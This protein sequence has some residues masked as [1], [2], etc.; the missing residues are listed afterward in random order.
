MNRVDLAKDPAAWVESLIKS[1]VAESPENS[2]KNP[3]GERAFME[4]L[5][6]FS[7]GDDPIYDQ[8]RA[9][10]G[11]FFWRPAEAFAAEFPEDPA[12]AQELTVIS[13]ILPHNPLTKA[14]N[15]EA[16]VY[17][18]ERWARARFFGEN[19]NMLLRSHLAAELNAA[20][21]PA[22]APQLCKAWARHDSKDY[23]FASSWSERHA[24]H[25]SGL[26]TFGLCD[27]LITPK[28]KAMRTG[29]VVARVKILPTPRP[30]T[31]HHAYCLFYSHG[32][33]GK[34]IPA[35]PV[36][37]L[38]EE[39]HDKIKCQRHVEKVCPQYVQKTYGFE[40][41]ACGLCQVAMPCTDHIPDP[42]EG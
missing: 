23:S 7:A 2:L 40:V 35:C 38:S 24:A 11:D 4:P 25:A 10:I 34:C 16:E 31:D 13:Y 20:G 28:G 15:S 37:A 1:F 3:A 18:S 19:F 8:M 42:S 39:G 12:P 32:T 33:C 26:G 14:E 9:H 36:G 21:A 29:S 41:P 27:G 30:Y 22:M 17:P 6:G 5:V